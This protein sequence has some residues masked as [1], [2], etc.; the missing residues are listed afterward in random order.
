MISENESDDFD[1]LVVITKTESE[2]NIIAILKEYRKVII[3]KILKMILK[4]L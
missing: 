3:L 1:D 2:S 4:V